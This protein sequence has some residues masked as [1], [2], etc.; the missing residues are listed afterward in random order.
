MFECFGRDSNP[1]HWLERPIYLTGLYD[2][3]TALSKAY[4]FFN[5]FQLSQDSFA[6]FARDHMYSESPADLILPEFLSSSQTTIVMDLWT[7]RIDC[8][9][10]SLERPPWKI[11]LA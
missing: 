7:T 8:I 4:A 3:S 5:L 6:R 11:P 9:N 10:L 1:G 2:R